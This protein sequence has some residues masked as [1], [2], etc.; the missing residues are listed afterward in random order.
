MAAD[1]FAVRVFAARNLV[2]F[3]GDV[4]VLVVYV[5]EITVRDAVALGARACPVLFIPL[6]CRYQF[7]FPPSLYFYRADGERRDQTSRVRGVTI[8]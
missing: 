6:E 2:G 3:N 5:A 1:V 7:S 4:N 8:P